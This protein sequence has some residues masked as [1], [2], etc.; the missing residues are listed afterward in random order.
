MILRNESVEGLVAKDSEL[1]HDIRVS[2]MRLSIVGMR[3]LTRTALAGRIW[4][5]RCK[6]LSMTTTTSSSLQLKPSKK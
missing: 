6:S 2:R 3:F 5:A 4:M 1:V